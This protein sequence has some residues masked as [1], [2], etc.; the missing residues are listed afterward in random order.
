MH[1]RTR[2]REYGRTDNR[3]HVCCCRF[4]VDEAHRIIVRRRLPAEIT[5][6]IID[7][8]HDDKDTL[9]SCA[10]THPSWLHRARYHLHKSVSLDDSTSGQKL[11]GYYNT[12]AAAYIRNLTLVA[13]PQPYAHSRRGSM[14]YRSRPVWTVASRFKNVRN[15]TLVFFDWRGAFK[16]Y[17]RLAEIGRHVTHLTLVISS[18]DNFADF[19]SFLRSFPQLTTLSVSSLTFRCIPEWGVG[20]NVHHDHGLPAIESPVTPN[21]RSVHFSNTHPCPSISKQLGFWMASLPRQVIAKFD[22]T[23]TGAGSV[24]GLKYALHGLGANLAHLEVDAASA[25]KLAYEGT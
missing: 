24:Y 14:S 25:A 4:S 6:S 8:L 12:G 21:L 3:N 13:P 1:R 15:L 20:Y 9:K 17:E 18:F 7:C 5:E 10:L 19:L 23:W 2:Y 22:L 11:S 16:S